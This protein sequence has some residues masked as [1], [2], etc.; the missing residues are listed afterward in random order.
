[1]SMDP[2]DKALMVFIGL[3]IAF[4]LAMF[5]MGSWIEIERARVSNHPCPCQ[6]AKK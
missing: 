4:V 1:M 3:L 5:A 2:D 6:T